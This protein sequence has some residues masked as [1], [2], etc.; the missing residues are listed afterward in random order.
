MLRVKCIYVTS[1]FPEE[2]FSG[3]EYYLDMGD[4]TTAKNWDVIAATYDKNKNFIGRFNK[5]HFKCM[6][7]GYSN[8]F[9]ISSIKRSGDR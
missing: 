2:I 7:D 3:G 4:S 6:E 8:R 9:L 5:K 1:E